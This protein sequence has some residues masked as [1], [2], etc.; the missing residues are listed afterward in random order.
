MKLFECG[1]REIRVTHNLGDT[2]PYDFYLPKLVE[3]EGL[4]LPVPV[5]LHDSQLWALDKNHLTAIAR[6]FGARIHALL[7]E[8][9][10][11]FAFVRDQNH[12]RVVIDERYLQW[13]EEFGGKEFRLFMEQ[14]RG[15][16]YS[17]SYDHAEAENYHNSI[18]WKMEKLG[19]SHG[20]RNSFWSESRERFGKKTRTFYGGKYLCIGSARN[21][22]TNYQLGAKLLDLGRRGSLDENFLGGKDFSEKTFTD[23]RERLIEYFKR[24]ALKIADLTYTGPSEDTRGIIQQVSANDTYERVESI[25]EKLMSESV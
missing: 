20:K 7:L 16:C 12:I 11:D 18:E 4:H 1:A 14:F 9:E 21:R 6:A 13:V 17:S 23:G 8:D 24:E 5:W 2:R 22:N 15:P 10:A 25:W 3:S 19:F